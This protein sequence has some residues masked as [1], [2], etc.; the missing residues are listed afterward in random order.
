[1]RKGYDND[2]RTAMTWVPEGR[3]GRVGLGK[4]GGDRT[5]KKKKELDGGAGARRPL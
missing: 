4:Y 5:A 2:C 1:M 3:R